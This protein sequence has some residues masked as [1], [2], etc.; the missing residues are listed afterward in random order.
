MGERDRHEHG[1]FSWT[2][3]STPDVDASG[4][5]YGALFGWDYDD[6]PLSEEDGGGFYRLAKLGGRTAAAMY[7][8]SEP[9]PAWAS[10]VTVDDVDATAARAAELGATPMGEPFDV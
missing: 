8:S 1:T 2:D 7:Q 10:Y 9:H 4:S 6:A 3:L 5:F